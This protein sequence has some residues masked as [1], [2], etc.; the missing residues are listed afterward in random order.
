MILPKKNDKKEE[1]KARYGVTKEIPVQQVKENEKN[2]KTQ[3]KSEVNSLDL[4]LRVEK[5]EGRFSVFESIKD[6][7]NERM[8]RLSEEIGELRSS[9]LELDRNF[10]SLEAKIEKT[11]Q[12]VSEIQPEKFGK[13]LQKKEAEIL[14]LQTDIEALKAIIAVL[15]RDNQSLRVILEKI[16][17]LDNLISMYNKLNEKI[18]MIDDAKMYVDRLAGK[19]ETIFTEMESKIKD[20]ENMKAKVQKLDDL[21]VDL[22]KMLDSISLKVPKLIEKDG[23]QKL[24]EEMVKKNMQELNKNYLVE[25]KTIIEQTKVDAKKEIEAE[26]Q[27][28][29]NTTSEI[30]MLINSLKTSL[31]SKE[32]HMH[33]QIK[34]LQLINMLLMS[35]TKEEIVKILGEIDMIK[36]KMSQLNMWDN[37]TQEL[38]KKTLYWLKNAWEYYQNNEIKEI[39]EQKLATLSY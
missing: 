15:K 16:K 29:V 30:V 14:K 32:N 25:L 11:I 37:Y 3:E 6:D 8:A 4:L 20:V 26:K 21:T 39:F 5:L 13:E 38:F 33:L 31:P 23:A 7:I 24:I 22:V 10:T 27:K 35:S 2:V 17:S 9:F 19:T 28:L 34:F 12:V 18:Q 1:L 36:N